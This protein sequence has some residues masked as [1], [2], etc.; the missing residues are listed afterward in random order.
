[1]KEVSI[2]KSPKRKKIVCDICK[3]EIPAFSSYFCFTEENKNKKEILCLDCV[4]TISKEK[5]V[6]YGFKPM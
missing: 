6:E 4:K 2:L 3:K 5:W 1:M